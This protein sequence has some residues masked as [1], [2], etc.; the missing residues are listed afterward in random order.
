MG[1]DNRRAPKSDRGAPLEIPIPL[2]YD[3]KTARGLL[4]GRTSENSVMAK[5]VEPRASAYLG[6][7]D[8]RCF[9]ASEAGNKPIRTLRE[10]GNKKTLEVVIPRDGRRR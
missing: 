7:Q 10:R 8:P 4:L 5:F 2:H 9:G 1:W 6:K 3:L